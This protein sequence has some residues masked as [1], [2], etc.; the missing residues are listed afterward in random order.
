MQ[1]AMVIGMEIDAERDSMSH[2]PNAHV[3]TIAENR[4]RAEAAA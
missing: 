2:S 3:F 4:I 1:R